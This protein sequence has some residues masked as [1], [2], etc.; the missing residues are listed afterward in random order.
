MCMLALWSYHS[1]RF[2]VPVYPF[3][4]VYMID[5]LRIPR[6]RYIKLS[7]ILLLACSA[8]LA[9]LSTVKDFLEKRDP[10]QKPV[11][12]TYDWLKNNTSPGAIVMSDDPASVYLDSERKATQWYTACDTN[13]FFDRVK[14]EKVDYVLVWQGDAFFAVGIVG[15]SWARFTVQRFTVAG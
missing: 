11:F 9:N 6:I 12:E 5:A 14:K 3:L 10:P 2:L 15:T 1:A 8:V 4:L 13:D 7:L